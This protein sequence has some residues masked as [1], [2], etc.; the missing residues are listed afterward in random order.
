MHQCS[1]S[2]T[3]PL[4][5]FEFT[6]T[7]TS[8]SFVKNDPSLIVAGSNTG[9]IVV[10]DARTGRRS[11]VSISLPT[12]SVISNSEIIALKVTQSEYY[13]PIIGVLSN[14]R[15]CKWK[16]SMLAAPEEVVYEG[17]TFKYGN[18]TCA[19]ISETSNDLCVFGT[20][21]GN[22]VNVDPYT[23][24]G[25]KATIL[26]NLKFPI[27][28]ISFHRSKNENNRFP[29]FLT[30][31]FDCSLRIWNA[32]KNC[33]L[34]VDNK[35]KNSFVEAKWCPS[36][37]S[38]YSTS[39]CY[40]QINLCDAV[41]N[42]VSFSHYNNQKQKLF[43]SMAWSINGTTLALGRTDGSISAIHIDEKLV[44]PTRDGLSKLNALADRQSYQ[45]YNYSDRSDFSF[46]ASF[47]SSSTLDHYK[48][49]TDAISQLSSTNVSLMQ[50]N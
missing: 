35:F 19:D 8:I 42:S 17:S 40:G 50:S 24:D 48:S 36:H 18:A 2:I 41:K 29:L 9:R 7:L 38:M 11:P 33:Q 22:I 46:D 10:W 28:S 34:F 16:L 1:N 49:S 13:S 20:Q 14:C 39:D 15:I 30:T 4:N 21:T 6:N 26:S 43:T 5:I 25:P 3:S 37:P 27:T 12:Q 47:K 31:S 45:E 44:T 23:E 32:Q